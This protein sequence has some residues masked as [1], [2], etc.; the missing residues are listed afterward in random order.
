MDEALSVSTVAPVMKALYE[1]IK[2]RSIAHLT[3]H[4]IPLELQL[5]PYLD[6]LLHS[7]GDEDFAEYDEVDSRGGAGT[8]G[9]GFSVAWRRPA[10]EPWKSLLLLGGPDDPG[11]QWTDVYAAIRGTNVREEDK[12]LAGQLIKFLETVDVTLSYVCFC[13]I[14]YHRNLELNAHVV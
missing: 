1:A 12:L 7:T 13:L 6:T 4:N 8:W 9:R 3:I 2:S 10:L 14:I 5:P 11:R